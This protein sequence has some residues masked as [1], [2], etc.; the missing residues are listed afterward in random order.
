MTEKDNKILDLIRTTI[1]AHEPT[2]EIILYGSRARG[3]ARKDS[4]WDVVVL[5]DKP[6]THLSMDERGTIDYDL[7]YKGMEQGEEINTFAYTKQQWD[8]LP[9]SIFKYNVQNEGV[10]L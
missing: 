9:P 1:R 8:N 10:R 2:A 3:D 4:D 5:L 6:S 7:W